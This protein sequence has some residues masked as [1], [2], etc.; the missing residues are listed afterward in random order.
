MTS[1]KRTIKNRRAGYTPCQ[2][3]VREAT[4]NDKSPATALTLA[5]ICNATHDPEGRGQ[6]M[7][8]L[9]QRLH[10][11]GKYWRHVYKSLIV[12]EFL[13][14]SAPD[15]VVTEIKQNLFSLQA[16]KEF[17]HLGK[18]GKDKGEN[19]RQRAAS[20]AAL[21]END[22]QLRQERAQGVPAHE[23]YTEMMGDK[24]LAKAGKTSVGS[25]SGPSG[26]P[27]A[28]SGPAAAP[29][30][31]APAP[32]PGGQVRGQNEYAAAPP[33]QARNPA[34]QTEEE[35]IRQAMIMSM[36]ERGREDFLRAKEQEQAELAMVLSLSMAEAN[37]GDVGGVGEFQRYDPAM[38]DSPAYSSDDGD[39]PTPP[40]TPYGGE[41]FGAGTPALP[42][43]DEALDESGAGAISPQGLTAEAGAEQTAA[44]L[45]VE[46]SIGS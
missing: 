41:F 43:Y 14:K 38:Y 3:D 24:A 7:A 8:M 2:I 39:E 18:G 36:G 12:L 32:A 4:S 15:P 28:A 13:T 21:L 46:A 6:V 5:R 29:A 35:L 23:R 30:A 16:L 25:R 45:E 17:Q 22:A 19:V 27:A 37:G 1:F 31:P 9:W 20:L 33:A 44:Y 40:T 34:V 11:K 26:V 42:S 10:D